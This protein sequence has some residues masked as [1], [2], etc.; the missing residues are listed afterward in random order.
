M[1][2]YSKRNHLAP[3]SV[4]VSFQSTRVSPAVKEAVCHCQVV[5]QSAS[6]GE[7]GGTILVSIDSFI[8]VAGSNLSR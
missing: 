4:S 1:K 6:I 2:K 7:L 8:P 5:A 3:S